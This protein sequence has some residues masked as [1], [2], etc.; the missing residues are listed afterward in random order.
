MLDEEVH[1]AEEPRRLTEGDAVAEGADDERADT[2]PQQDMR[3]LEL[4]ARA[5]ARQDL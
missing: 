4:G 1:H 2:V 5:S 3:K